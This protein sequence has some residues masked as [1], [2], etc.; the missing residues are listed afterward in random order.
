MKTRV[1]KYIQTLSW[2]AFLKLLW[3]IAFTCR[4]TH[5]FLYEHTIK[6]KNPADFMPA[7]EEFEYLVLQNVKQIEEMESKGYD[8][9]FKRDN[10]KI[11]L[12]SGVIAFCVFIQKEL[13]HIGGVAF[14]DE[15]KIFIDDCPY[16]VDFAGG[17]ACIGGTWTNPKYRGKGLVKYVS[18]QRFEFLRERGI[19]ICRNAVETTNIASQLEQARFKPRRYAR[20]RYIKL[21]FFI[22]FWKE[23]P[24][25]PG[26]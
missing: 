5:H 17:E 23:K 9:L 6:E 16:K 18:F 7:I 14:S 22:R 15:A 3:R 25:T 12:E 11:A 24:L 2:M 1:K 20:A 10:T 4:C 8:F 21:P 26:I 19:G 13:A